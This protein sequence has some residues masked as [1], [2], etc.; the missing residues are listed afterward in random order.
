MIETQ[1]LRAWRPGDEALLT[2][3][4]TELSPASLHAR[5]LAG[6]PALPSAYLRLV[7]TAP[8]WRWDGV[9][10]L[11]GDRMI[12]W[13]EFARSSAECT[14]ADLAVTVV[15]A[16]QRRGIGTALVAALLPRCRAAGLAGLTAHVAPSNVAARAALRSWFAAYPRP[17]QVIWEDGLLR[18]QLPL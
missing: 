15:D 9:V 5:F 16:W 12:G 11:R 18:Y 3:A 17:I 13:A 6:V 8:R 7:A 10:A 14:E 2:Q 1:E 4:G